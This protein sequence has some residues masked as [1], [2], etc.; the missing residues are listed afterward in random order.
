MTRKLA[1]LALIF[2]VS[3]G[4]PA[5]TRTGVGQLQVSATVVSSSQLVEQPDGSFRLVVANAP[6]QADVRDLQLAVNR[7]NSNVQKALLQ[8]TVTV[9]LVPPAPAPKPK[10]NHRH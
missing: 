2:L 7:L 4:M 5:Q 3:A 8:D 10:R 1:G 9:P 6:S